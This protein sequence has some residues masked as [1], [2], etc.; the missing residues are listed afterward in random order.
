MTARRAVAIITVCAGL[1][2]WV[3]GALLLF[4]MGFPITHWLVVEKIVIGWASL[5]AGAL[6]WQGHRFMHLAGVVAWGMVAVW[7]ASNIAVLI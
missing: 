7:V 4:R 1:G 2:A 5:I 6:L 3:V